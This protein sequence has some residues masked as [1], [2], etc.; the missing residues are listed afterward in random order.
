[1]VVLWSEYNGKKL[2]R[3]KM[4]LK[5]TKAPKIPQIGS[6]DTQIGVSAVFGTQKPEIGAEAGRGLPPLRVAATP[7]AGA[8]SS[9]LP[10]IEGLDT[11]A[12]ISLR[13][14][15]EANLPPT[16]L[17]QLDLEAEILLQYHQVKSM[18]AKVSG[19]ANVPAN[20]KAQVANSCASVLEQLIKMQTR[21]YS[22]ERIKAIEVAVIK[23]LKMLPAESQ[24]AFFTAYEMT[25]A[26]AQEAAAA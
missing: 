1:M 11:E 14:Q 23:T 15:I 16:K 12:L 17:S 7:G 6:E 18:L 19:D 3:L 9:G 10:S 8:E 22:A 25:Y 13:S 2:K 4:V 5:R 26:Q 21:M 20:Q 24:Q